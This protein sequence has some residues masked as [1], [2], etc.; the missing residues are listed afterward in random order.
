MIVT[1]L[2]KIV[3]GAFAPRWRSWQERW[4]WICFSQ[5]TDVTG[6]HK[7]P[8]KLV[9]E[10]ELTRFDP[11]QIWPGLVKRFVNPIC[12]CS[13]T[14]WNRLR[15]TGSIQSNYDWDYQKWGYLARLQLSAG[16]SGEEQVTQ[17]WKQPERRARHWRL[18]G[19]TTLL[20]RMRDKR[21][22]W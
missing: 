11:G 19:L 8:L 15:Q 10:C 21:L 3:T 7:M 2:L 5:L 18:E 6:G 1:T 20:R 9:R 13:I 4:E 14:A 16:R 12:T 17:K 22:R